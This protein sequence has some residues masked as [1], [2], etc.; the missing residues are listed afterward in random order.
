M[1]V[2]MVCV[3][4]A[5]DRLHVRHQ[6][7]TSSRIPPTTLKLSAFEQF[8]AAA[9]FP[10]I[11]LKH[12]EFQLQDSNAEMQR[13]RSAPPQKFQQRVGL[14]SPPSPHTSS[15]QL[16]PDAAQGITSN[17]V[18]ALLRRPRAA[19]YM[20]PPRAG[21]VV[22]PFMEISPKGIHALLSACSLNGDDC[23][24]DMGCGKGNVAA[25]ILA[26]Y[27]CQ[28]I[29]VEINVSLARIA[30]QR[31]AKYGDRAQVLVDDICQL[32]L[33]DA[34]VVISFFISNALQQVSSHMA[35]SL[36][37]GSIWL[38]YAWP[39]PG[40]TT[41][42]PASDGVYAYVIGGRLWDGFERFHR[43]VTGA[44]ITDIATSSIGP[45]PCERSPDQLSSKSL[46]APLQSFEIPARGRTR[47]KPPLP[48]F[49]SPS[50]P[51]TLDAWRPQQRMLVR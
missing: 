29:G 19:G 23:V 5:S 1:V 38:N 24:Y 25:E 39:V 18:A 49:L 26:H 4:K 27:P 33:S 32:D 51:K 31:L 36:R 37:P 9:H 22:C 48:L 50:P 41:S 40:W 7:S 20:H 16:F 14:V 45:P 17:K 11:T 44:S 43:N 2:H 6:L 15:H 46:E 3:E 30:R 10:A 21:N 28:V 34:T 13:S 12:R 42:R 47:R 8:N 35:S